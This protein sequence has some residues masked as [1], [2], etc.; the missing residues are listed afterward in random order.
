VDGTYLPQHPY[1]PEPAAMAANVP[2]IICSTVNELA[3]SRTEASLEEVTLAQVKERL[4]TGYRYFAGLGDKASMV[5][6]AYAKAFPDKKP[7]EI[8][9]M[10]VSNRRT[11][12][13]LADMKS[14][15]QAPVY[16]A[17]FGWQ[18]PLFDNRMRAFHCLDI[19]FWFYN[20]NLMLT[21]T[22]GGC[23]PRKLSEQMAGALLNFMRTGDP[24]G[25]SLPQWP[26]YTSK[27]GETMMLDD[28]LEV[29]NDPDREVR[30]SFPN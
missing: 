17:W 7:V 29:K 25:G 19:C 11:T 4:K 23:R 21:H 3:P 8:W 12:I 9:S 22:G 10:V 24:N 2:M 6:D 18:P 13:T 27:N 1:Y 15:Q 16:V 14:K 5:V 28:I 20:T 26:R 30:E